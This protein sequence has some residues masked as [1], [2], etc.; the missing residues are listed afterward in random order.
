M[1][2]TIL[3]KIEPEAC[4]SL[5]NEMNHMIVEIVLPD[6]PQKN[7]KI[8]LNS[9]CLIL[10]AISGNIHYTKYMCFRLPVN[11]EKAIAAY[12]NGLLRIEM[13]LRS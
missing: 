9:R 1:K 12:G 2:P 10:L 3:K 5:D 8:R 7:I 4:T 11:A 6:V 13:P